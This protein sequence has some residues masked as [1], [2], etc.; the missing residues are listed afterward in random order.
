MPVVWGGDANPPEGNIRFCQI[1]P[2][3]C[4]KLKEFGPRGGHK[5]LSRSIIFEFF[6][7]GAGSRTV[8]EFSDFNEFGESELKHELGSIIG[9]AFHNLS[10]WSMQSTTQSLIHDGSFLQLLTQIDL[11]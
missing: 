9:P 4:M 3:S 8:I 5:R 10:C 7:N 6:L 11:N 1:S 2:K